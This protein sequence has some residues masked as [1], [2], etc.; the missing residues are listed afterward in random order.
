MSHILGDFLA[1]NPKII[2]LYV[3]YATEFADF[4]IYTIAKLIPYLFFYFFNG[5]KFN[6]RPLIELINII[7]LCLCNSSNLS[8]TRTSERP[9]FR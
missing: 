9:F 8:N 1:E 4:P 7:I 2:L 6:Q 3:A 5:D